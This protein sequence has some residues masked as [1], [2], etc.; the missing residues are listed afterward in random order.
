MR[1]LACFGP[2]LLP[3]RS[4]PRQT[5]HEERHGLSNPRKT[6]INEGRARLGVAVSPT[7]EHVE[8]GICPARWSVPPLEIEQGPRGVHPRRGR[9]ALRER[10]QHVLGNNLA[11]FRRRRSSDN[12][13]L[14]H[15]LQRKQSC[16]L[17]TSIQSNRK[18]KDF[19]F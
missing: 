15:P 19:L 7:C 2:R 9:A 4:T 5:P 14:A 3:P 10:A 12:R 17:S 11:A 18:S 16:G 8:R 1:A 13:R 6:R